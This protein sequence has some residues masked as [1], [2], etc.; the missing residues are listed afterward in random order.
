MCSACP[1]LLA[2]LLRNC[3]DLQDEAA[4]AALALLLGHLALSRGHLALLLDAVAAAAAAG[5]AH[6][7]DT[8]GAQPGAAAPRHADAASCRG[9]VTLLHLLA[10]E[11]AVCPQALF[12]ER[13]RG[14]GGAAA[15]QAVPAVMRSLAAVVQSAC[16]LCSDPAVCIRT[17]EADAPEA[18]GSAAPYVLEAAL[19]VRRPP[20][21]GRRAW[22]GATHVL[23]QLPDRPATQRPPHVVCCLLEVVSLR[24]H[25]P[26]MRCWLPLS[27][28]GLLTCALVVTTWPPGCCSFGL[29]SG[30]L[31]RLRPSDTPWLSRTDLAP[32]GRR[33]RP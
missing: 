13:A 18:G 27:A 21:C 28:C 33:G 16:G 10:H 22:E 11:V 4:N 29:R 8:P 26:C 19:R 9:S 17:N 24:T 1:Q 25:P 31:S 5:D 7:G 30:L 6:A 15:A 3:M 23:C 20:P 12:G 32:C 2:H 14:P